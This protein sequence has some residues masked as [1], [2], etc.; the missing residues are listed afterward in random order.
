[1][2]SCAGCLEF[3]FAHRTNQALPKRRIIVNHQ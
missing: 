2:I 3:A 1:M